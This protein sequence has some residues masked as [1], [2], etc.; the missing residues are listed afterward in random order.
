MTDNYCPNG[1]WKGVVDF[2]KKE[3]GASRGDPGPIPSDQRQDHLQEQ[4]ERGVKNY[5]KVR[6]MGVEKVKIRVACVKVI[7][8]RPNKMK[9]Q[10]VSEV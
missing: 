10:Q 8:F 1:T 5:L 2:E 7:A 9:A 6:G 3:R 4:L